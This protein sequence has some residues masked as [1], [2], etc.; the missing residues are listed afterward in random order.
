MAFHE[1]SSQFDQFPGE[2]ASLFAAYSTA[3]PEVEPSVEFM[4]KLWDRIDKQQRITYSFR[5]LARG[6]VTVAAGLCLFLSSAVLI[7]PQISTSHAGTYV[8]VLAD[9]D[10][11]LDSSATAL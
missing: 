11:G 4:P 9:T 8:D 5:R 7:P 1:K 2:V 10:D 3:V 6:F